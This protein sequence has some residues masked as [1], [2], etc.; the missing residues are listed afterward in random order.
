MASIHAYAE[1]SRSL[2]LILPNRSMRANIDGPK[3]GCFAAL[4]VNSTSP[5]ARLCSHPPCTASAPTARR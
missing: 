1:S 3:V 5:A 4:P 2:V